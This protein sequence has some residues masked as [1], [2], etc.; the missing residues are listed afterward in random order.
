MR[1]SDDDPIEL[2]ECWVKH[3]RLIPVPVFFLPSVLIAGLLLWLSSGNPQADLLRELSLVVVYVP[4]VF[5]FFCNFVQVGRS[6]ELEWM[7]TTILLSYS[8]LHATGRFHVELLLPVT[9]LHAA[10]I[11]RRANLDPVR[12]FKRGIFH[13]RR[14]NLEKAQRDLARCSLPVAGLFLTHSLAVRQD[15]EHARVVWHA[16]RSRVDPEVLRRFRLLDEV[17]ARLADEMDRP[18]R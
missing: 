11:C 12:V 17:L 13:L 15:K 14:G 6:R 10:W 8:M 7:A 9:A 18:V 2:L 5:M 3:H 1:R 16:S 4:C